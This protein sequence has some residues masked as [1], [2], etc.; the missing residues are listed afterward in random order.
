MTTLAKI[1]LATLFLSLSATGLSAQDRERPRADPQ[2]RAERMTE[3]MTKELELTERQRTEVLLINQTH[4][5]KM[6]EAGTLTDRG[7][8]RAAATAARTEKQEALATVL[9]AEQLKKL[10][11]L[12]SQRQEGRGRRAPGKRSG[13]NR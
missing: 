6:G 12:Q 9:T 10:A 7:A 4:A 5:A 11:E 13:G 8:K 1:F 2:Q 3:R